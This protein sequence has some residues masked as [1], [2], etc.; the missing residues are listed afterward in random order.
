MPT[1]QESE[2]K[3]ARRYEEKPFFPMGLLRV[4][5]YGVRVYVIRGANLEPNEG[6]FADPYVRCKLGAVVKTGEVRR[7][8]LRPDFYETF[9]FATTL[10]GP[11]TLKLQLRD[12]SR[13]RRAG[14]AAPSLFFFKS[15]APS[16]PPV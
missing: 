12:H 8:T 1:L 6:S 15:A 16:D 4:A 3:P 7:K 14:R 13:W 9:E 10:P 5:T 11:A 2:V